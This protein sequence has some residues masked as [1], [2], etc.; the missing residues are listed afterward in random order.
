MAIQFLVFVDRLRLFFS[1][2]TGRRKT[3]PLLLGSLLDQRERRKEER[4]KGRKREK[5][6]SYSF[7]A[8]IR[9]T[10]ALLVVLV[11]MSNPMLSW[12]FAVHP[13]ARRPVPWRKLEMRMMM[14][15]SG[16]ER[17]TSES[18]RPPPDRVDDSLPGT[19]PTTLV[20]TRLPD[21]V[22]DLEI[23]VPGKATAAAYNKV[24]T[25]LSKTLVIP[26]FRRGSQ[27]PAAVLEQAMASSSKDG[28]TD[29]NNN[30]Q[31]NKNRLKRQAIHELLL[32]LV[33]PT[34][35]AQKLDPIGQATLRVP[36][37]ELALSFRP[38]EPFV[39]PVRCD[40]WPE[41]EWKQPAKTQ[42][43][44]TSTTTTD[45][46]STAEEEDTTTTTT[47]TTSRPVYVGLS[48]TYTRKPMDQA[49]LDLA[50]HDLK[51]RYATLEPIDEPYVLQMGDACTVNMEGY[52]AAVNG[53]K[54]EKLPNA[55]S[56]DNVEVVLGAGRYMT[57]LVEGL[58]GGKVGETKQVTVSFPPVRFC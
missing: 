5:K 47:T 44:A 36:V 15:T 57:G 18:S 48:G 21:S 46:S 9:Q 54:G 28:K 11:A 19:T 32:T 12:S 50:L 29:N 43:K 8:M 14:T 26:G 45:S 6:V 25:E 52:L 27:I 33:E 3:V 49:K 58:V 10:A 39:L 17:T 24:I 37:E 42:T 7:L 34:L 38:G 22:V 40:V 56:G 2:T 41:I 30:N 31:S 1:C 35:Q 20:V 51:E 13:P 4:K 23:P 16:G 55:A 53:G